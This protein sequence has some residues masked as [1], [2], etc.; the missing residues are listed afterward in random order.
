MVCRAAS[1]SAQAYLGLR[2]PLVS[3]LSGHCARTGQVLCCEDT[4][5]DPR[6]EAEACRRLGIRSLIL[7]PLEHEH[8]IAGVLKVFQRT[9]GAFDERDVQ[10][11]LVT[12]D[13]LSAAIGRALA[14]EAN[15]ALIQER[16]AALEALRESEH[17][18]RSMVE[19][20]PIGACIV[21]E[22]G[23]FELVN[24]AYCS[25][26]GYTRE[27]M[28]GLS[29][30]QVMPEDRR[31]GIP[32]G[33]APAGA[34][35]AASLGEYDAVARGGRQ[36]TVIASSV[37]FTG[38]DGR[39][40]RAS[41]VLDITEQKRIEHYLTH[42]AHH[43][44][45][46][47][48]PNRVLFHDRLTQALL[49]AERHRTPV[50]VLLID[51]DRFKAVNDSLGHAAGDRLLQGLATRLHGCLRA[52]DTVARMGGDEFAVLLPHTDAAGAIEVARKLHEQLCTP[53]PLDDV[54]VEVG[55]SIGIAIKDEPGV[56]GALMLHRSDVAMYAAKRSE[57]GCLVYREDLESQLH[58][59][60]LARPA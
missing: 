38:A 46:T 32:H 60:R 10:S 9:P 30:A 58:D 19:L 14:F 54:P 37:S 57:A 44:A 31:R 51:L 20:A 45:L 33:G 15:R 50:A 25:L 23:A 53:L 5:T 48:L 1:D 56:D 6:A 21:D 49:S 2:L 28:L 24:D 26:F 41:F 42:V 22:G 13:V 40:H 29:L 36:I 16:T 35:R 43:D 7:V 3:S 18:L 47:G 4:E 39:S 27:E 34:E 11:L 52:S 55:A 17:R 59:N 12:A 8:G